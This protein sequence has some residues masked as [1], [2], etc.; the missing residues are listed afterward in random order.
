MAPPRVLVLDCGGVTNPDCEAGNV[1]V[2]LAMGMP[3]DAARRGHK[4]A[5]AEARSNPSAK[6]YWL[7]AMEVAG[8]VPEARTEERVAACEAAIAPALSVSFEQT[9]S[10]ARSLRARGIIIGVIS[11]HL[12]YPP[13]F[14]YCAQ[15]SGLHALVSDPSLMVISQAVGCAKPD[16]SIYR[17]FFERLLAIDP[18]LQ[19]A[20]VLFVD[21]KEKNVEAARAL[22]WQGL[23][24]RADAQ[25]S[26]AFAR[27]C[28]ALFSFSLDT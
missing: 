9:L 14:E 7:H 21:D 16:A 15:G 4:A 22:G 8:V 12:V 11:N 19:P 18:T 26:D 25:P 17:L 10:V 2:A 27:G 24:Y 23:V 1:A 5:W 28:E 3:A 20:D 13:L 6:S